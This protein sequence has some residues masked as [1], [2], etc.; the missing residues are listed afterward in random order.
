MSAKIDAGGRYHAET[1]PA[2]VK[3]D[4]SFAWFWHGFLHRLDGPAVRLVFPDRVEE[5]FWIN[6]I[7]QDDARVITLKDPACASEKLVA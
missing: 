6:G 7:E 3:E 5:Q 4:G 1:E 2:V